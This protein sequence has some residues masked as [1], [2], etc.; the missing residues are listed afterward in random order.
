MKYYIQTHK[1]QNF[2]KRHR[3]HIITK[4]DSL[5]FFVSFA[6]GSFFLSFVNYMHY[7]SN[8]FYLKLNFFFLTL[9]LFDWFFTVN[10]EA[11]NGFHTKNVQVG[12]FKGMILFILSEIMFFFSIF[13]S[14]FN[15]KINPS[16]YIE[17]I[18]PPIGINIIKM[19][20][21]P[22]LNTVF[23]VYSGL[24]LMNS[25]F[26]LK[27]GRFYWSYL[28]LVIT[29]ILGLFFVLVQFK[30]YS[31]STFSFNDSC[32]G[33]VFFLLTGF[34]GF[35]VI[36]GLIFL[37]ICCYRLFLTYKYN[38]Y[39]NKNILKLFL[40][41]FIMLK[42]FY[43]KINNNKIDIK[44]INKFDFNSYIKYILDLKF[45]DLMY[46]FLY[47]FIINFKLKNKD[48]NENTNIKDINLKNIDFT[49]I[50][51]KK[52][53]V[54]L[55]IQNYY[56]S[57]TNKNLISYCNN[58]KK[59]ILFYFIFKNIIKKL[60]LYEFIT[61][62]KLTKNNNFN[63]FFRSYNFFINS[64]KSSYNLN[65]ISSK[66]KAF[67]SWKNLLLWINYNN[68]EVDTNKGFNWYTRR[69][70]FKFILPFIG[71]KRDSN[72]G[73]VCASWYWHFVDAIWIFVISV[74]YS[75]FL[76]ILCEMEYFVIWS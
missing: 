22:L 27:K 66:S 39:K 40:K 2:F 19:N 11:V 72:V 17:C 71:F 43:S 45:N 4:N 55:S 48:N 37:I 5:P 30:E 10:K 21:F 44:T 9:I 59:N 8:S 38:F 13:W 31:D 65:Y 32:Y 7:D 20:C 35:H 26:Y 58:Q 36:V 42:I 1:S 53:K 57:S 64:L 76:I 62:L 28:N 73:Y 12:I 74:I 25:I 49:L 6:I 56:L 68:L 52:D 47:C 75:D 23:L 46:I 15:F 41:T 54:K 3:F 29:I 67:Y 70:D 33:S 61:H 24:F 18:F 69:M 50:G 34:H 14:F 16:L 63:D 51:D 60:F